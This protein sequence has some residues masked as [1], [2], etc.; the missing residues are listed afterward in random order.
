[1]FAGVLRIFL[2][3]VVMLVARFV[4]GAARI[5]GC[6]VG[7]VKVGTLVVALFVCGA[8]RLF[9]CKIGLVKLGTLVGRW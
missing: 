8:A 3:K 6:K 5:F 4:C 9:G 7:L 1:M 2:V